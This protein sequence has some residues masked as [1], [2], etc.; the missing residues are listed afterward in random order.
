MS[1]PKLKNL[2]YVIPFLLLIAGGYFS[3]IAATMAV[4][5]GFTLKLFTAGPAF[6]FLGIATI[7]APVNL[8][9]TE[10]ATLDIKEVLTVNAKWKWI[11]WIAAIIA[12]AVWRN[13]VLVLFARLFG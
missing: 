3:F 8:P 9:V 7:I 10:N 2:K 4:S 12:G 1:N 6:V 5:A 13:D 11:V